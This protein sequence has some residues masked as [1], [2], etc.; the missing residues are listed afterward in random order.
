MASRLFGD[1][2]SSS[3]SSSDEDS[4]NE[5]LVSVH[6]MDETEEE[7][8]KYTTPV[9][10]SASR[11][12]SPTAASQPVTEPRKT[13]NFEMFVFTANQNDGDDSDGDEDGE[14]DSGDDNGQTSMALDASDIDLTDVEAP[15]APKPSTATR[16]FDA[17]LEFMP[18]VCLT[19]TVRC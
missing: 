5:Q 6:V 17:E 13:D 19:F 12:S 2:S 3:G 8:S 10:R 18:N 14:S 15:V 16:D 7:D 9:S 11:A 4:D 1:N